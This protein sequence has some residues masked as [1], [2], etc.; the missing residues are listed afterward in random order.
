MDYIKRIENKTVLVEA[1]NKT[2]DDIKNGQKER[3]MAIAN[4]IKESEDK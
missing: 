1:G 2:E 3:L 4:K